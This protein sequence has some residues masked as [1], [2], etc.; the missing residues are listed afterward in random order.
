MDI[1]FYSAVVGNLVITEYF[2]SARA[3]LKAYDVYGITALYIAVAFNKNASAS[4]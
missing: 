1:R 2:I 3:D 4:I